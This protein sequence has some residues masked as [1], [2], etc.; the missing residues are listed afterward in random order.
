MT[1]TVSRQQHLQQHQRANR[2]HRHHSDVALGRT[3]PVESRNRY[4]GVPAGGAPA[5]PV[6]SA[7]ELSGETTCVDQTDYSDNGVLPRQGLLRDESG[8]SWWSLDDQGGAGGGGGGAPA[9]TR[10]GRPPA[11]TRG[12]SWPQRH[13]QRKCDD[14]PEVG[15]EGAEQYE[16]GRS[17]RGAGLWSGLHSN[18][19]GG[20]TGTGSGSA[21][22]AGESWEDEE[23]DEGLGQAEEEVAALLV[24]LGKTTEEFEGFSDSEDSA[25]ARPVHTGSV[26][27]FSGAAVRPVAVSSTSQEWSV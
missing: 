7:G 1:E 9:P 2:P 14:G 27:V 19:A 4:P 23:S 21:G 8:S 10:F 5:N 18:S 25:P 3:P 11:P 24:G 26:R 22:S 6:L 20:G 16:N 15:G 13:Q 17:A 12:A